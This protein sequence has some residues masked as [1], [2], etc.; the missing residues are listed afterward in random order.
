MGRKLFH[1][2]LSCPFNLLELGATLYPQDT[3]SF[4]IFAPNQEALDEVKQKIAQILAEE[5]IFSH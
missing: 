1:A 3:D 5:V 4:K 2:N